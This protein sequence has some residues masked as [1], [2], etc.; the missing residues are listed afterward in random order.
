MKTTDP[1]MAELWKVKD[2]N[3]QRFGDLKA[4]VAHLSRTAK[5]PHA[6]GTIKAPNRQVAARRSKS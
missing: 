1:V 6:G 4:Y 3:V 2:L 5:Q